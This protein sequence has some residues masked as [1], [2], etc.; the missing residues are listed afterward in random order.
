M[1]RRW[2]RMGRFLWFGQV[3]RWKP[4]VFLVFSSSSQWCFDHR[5]SM[6]SWLNLLQ[7]LEA[8]SREFFVLMFP[9]NPAS[10]CEFRWDHLDTMELFKNLWSL[11]FWEDLHYLHFGSDVFTCLRRSLQLCWLASV[12]YWRPATFFCRNRGRP[13]VD[14]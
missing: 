6:A 10:K 12:H 3:V 4:R 5:F 11:K 14:Q 7:F 1:R 8:G 2:V 13:S 9:G